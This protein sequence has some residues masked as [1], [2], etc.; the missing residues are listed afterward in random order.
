M[1]VPHKRQRSL[2][3]PL[4]GNVA[5]LAVAPK[6]PVKTLAEFIAWAKANPKDAVF[7]SPGRGNIQSFIGLMLARAAGITLGEIPYKGGAPLVQDL[8]AGCGGADVSQGAS[9]TSAR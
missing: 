4:V 6:L 2:A 9:C 3:S 8:V 5:R 7:G 1:Q